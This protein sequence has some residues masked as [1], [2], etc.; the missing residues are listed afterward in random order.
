MHATATSLRTRD[1]WLEER[2]EILS[3]AARA[4]PDTP[5]PEREELL[6]G[7]FEFLAEVVEHTIVDER[8]L[9]PRVAARL[10]DPLAAAP[11]HYESRAI[12]WW[13]RELGRA[14][15]T[16]TAA[17]QRLLYGI[18]ALVKVHLSR[19]EELFATAFDSSTWPAG[20]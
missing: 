16:D 8:E 20:T 7:V 2:A 4:L 3:E 6:R 5:H 18:Y 9:Y 15:I 10:G 14:D 1:A 13:I 19:E 11:M 17:L 12:R